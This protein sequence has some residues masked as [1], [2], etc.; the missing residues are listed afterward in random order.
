MQVNKQGDDNT[1]MIFLSQV[2]YLPYAA[3]LAR[4]FL[5][6]ELV[7]VSGPQTD[8]LIYGN[9]LKCPTFFRKPLIARSIKL[10]SA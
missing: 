3:Y 5:E 4:Q 2:D 10:V 9:R 7:T 1:N 8:T 6:L